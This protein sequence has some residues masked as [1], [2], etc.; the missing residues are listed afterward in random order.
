M[1]VCVCVCGVFFWHPIIDLGFFARVN[2]THTHTHTHIHTHI[3]AKLSVKTAAVEIWICFTWNAALAITNKLLNVITLIALL[4][5]KQYIYVGNISF[6]DAL[7]TFP[8]RFHGVQK[9]SRNPLPYF[10]NYFS[11]S[12]KGSFI[13]TI[14]QCMAFGAPVVEQWLEWPLYL[15]QMFSYE[16]SSI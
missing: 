14:P 12:S 2:F 8:L 11:I 3:Y 4:V 5:W 9:W 10:M 1:C 15:H 13:Y 7:D 16:Y 6:N